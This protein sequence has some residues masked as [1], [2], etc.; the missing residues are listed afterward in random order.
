MHNLQGK[1]REFTRPQRPQIGEIWRARDGTIQEVIKLDDIDSE[2]LPAA[3]IRN[4]DSGAVNTVCLDGREAT[5][6]FKP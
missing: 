3:H 2:I 5:L 6:A 4:K 1:A